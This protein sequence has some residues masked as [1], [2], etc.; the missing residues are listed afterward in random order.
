MFAHTN[1]IAAQSAAGAECEIR[2]APQVSQHV[3]MFPI[4]PN[5]GHV[6]NQLLVFL[7]LLASRRMF[8][9]GTKLTPIALLQADWFLV[10]I[11]NCK[12]SVDKR[13]Q[14]FDRFRSLL[15]RFFQ[16]VSWNRPTRCL[17]S[18][19]GTLSNRLV[20]CCY[21]DNGNAVIGV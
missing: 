12:D 19:P 20:A 14:C 13:R 8:P 21:V 15:D 7:M 6:A 17:G 2:L 3:V 16:Q 10:I 18:V 1:S 11:G 4:L 9:R 5:I